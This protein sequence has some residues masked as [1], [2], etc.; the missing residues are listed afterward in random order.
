VRAAG[1]RADEHEPADELRM[2][3]RERLREVA[4]HR[5]PGDVRASPAELL[6]RVVG[7]LLD[8]VRPGRPRRAAGAAVLDGDAME[9][10]R[11][12]GELALPRPVRVAEPV[13]KQQRRA[14]AELVDV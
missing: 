8:R 12:L 2:A 3:Q 14:V 10:R 9:A 6:G 4:A 5:V 1:R 11:E 7:H 13:E